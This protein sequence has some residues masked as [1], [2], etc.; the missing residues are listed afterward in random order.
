[1]KRVLLVFGTRPEAVKMAPIA[2]GLKDM[3][4]I[5]ARVCVTAQHRSM[6]DETLRIFGIEPDFD[7]DLMEPDQSLSAI[8]SVALRALDPVL[9][10]FRPHWVLV[11]GDTTDDDGRRPCS[12]S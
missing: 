1:M 12:I 9:E 8:A 5:E 4:D 3:R 2:L 11:Q 6:L 7:L 10:E